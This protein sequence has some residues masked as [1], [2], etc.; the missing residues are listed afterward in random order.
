MIV[1]V[2]YFLDIISETFENI[3]KSL[4]EIWNS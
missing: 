1:L 3:F 4:K 2:W